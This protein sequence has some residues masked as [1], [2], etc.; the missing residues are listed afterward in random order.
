MP[1][2]LPSS[3]STTL[4]RAITISSA[5][6]VIPTLSLG[7]AGNKFFKLLAS[8]NFQQLGVQ[9]LPPSGG[10]PGVFVLGFIKQRRW[11]RV[12]CFFQAIQG[13]LRIGVERDEDQIDGGEFRAFTKDRWIFG[14]DNCVA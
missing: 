5:R 8:S 11:S 1:G 14:Q 2:R 13:L 7:K 4:P 12:Q 10:S 9:V 3:R 6:R